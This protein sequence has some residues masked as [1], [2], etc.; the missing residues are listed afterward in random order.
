MSCF[1]AADWRGLEAAVG[2]DQAG[3]ARRSL[4][5]VP[6]S[7]SVVRPPARGPGH[8]HWPQASRPDSP[9]PGPALVN[10]LLILVWGLQFCWVRV[11]GPF[12]LP[13]PHGRIGAVFPRSGELARTPP[14]G[15]GHGLRVGSAGENIHL[16]TSQRARGPRD[17]SRDP[18]D[19]SRGPRDRS[20]GPESPFCKGQHELASW[21]KARLC[22]HP[23]A[24]PLLA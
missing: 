5:R 6:L 17:R 23:L 21:R 8:W 18:R 15:L 1:S 22:R 19:R 13:D 12:P 10:N 11:P 9:G 3:S 4:G 14:E 2:L 20:R 16:R 7:S 24:A